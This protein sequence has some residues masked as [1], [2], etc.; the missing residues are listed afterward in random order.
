VRT[1]QKKKKK[2]KKKSLIYVIALSIYIYNLFHGKNKSYICC[3]RNFSYKIELQRIC[4]RRFGALTIYF[5]YQNVNRQT[6]VLNSHMGACIS[7][8]RRVDIINEIS[9]VCR[10]RV[11]NSHIY[12]WAP[13]SPPSPA[14]GSDLFGNVRLI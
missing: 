10:Q 5:S 1:C 6:R 8:G 7:V 4:T 3:C 13:A 12:A 2:K 9:T 11:L 14:K